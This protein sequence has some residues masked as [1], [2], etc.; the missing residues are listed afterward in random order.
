[1]ATSVFANQSHPVAPYNDSRIDS[2]YEIVCDS[3]IAFS[4]KLKIVDDLGGLSFYS[5]YFHKLFALFNRLLEQGIKV[6]HKNGM[7]FCYNS[8]ADLYF[9][10]W[11]KEETEIYLDS[12]AMCIDKSSNMQYLA[13]YYRMKAQYIQRY[14]PN[15]TPEAVIYYQ[16]SLSYY[17]KSGMKG[18][19]A[20]VVIILR[21]LTI[22]GFQRGD[23]A[24]VCKNILRIAELK[25]Q[26][27]FPMIDFCL[28]EM[29][30]SLYSFYYQNLPEAVYLDSAIYYAKECLAL[31][32]KGVLP[33]YYDHGAID[34]YVA[35]A[36]L[37]NKKEDSEIEPIDSLLSI[38]RMKYD[39][40]DSISL[41]RIYHTKARMFY[42][43]NMIDSAETVAL[44]AQ[45]YLDDGY[46]NRYYSQ[47]KGNI[48]L[49]HDIY[50]DKG[51]FQ[52]V[53]EYNEL[54][55]KK[56]EE[57][58]ANEVKELELQ[59]EFELKESEIERLKS[60]RSYQE[61]RYRMSVLFCF[62]LALTIFFILLL[63]RLKKRDLN[64]QIA[65]INKGK[66]EAKLKLKLKEEY[67]VKMQLERYE[68]LSDFHLKEMELIG[69][70]KDLDQLRQDK[71]L[72]DRQVELY[73][74][75][76]KTCEA[77]ANSKKKDLGFDTQNVVTEDIKRLINKYLKIPVRDVYIRNLERLDKSYIEILRKRSSENLSISYLKY[78][79]CF[80]ISMGIS[81]VAE[82]F[83]I[84]QSSVHMIRYRLKKKFGLGNDDDL[85]LFLQK[86]AFLQT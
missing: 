28:K 83:S 71:E 2:L 37:M 42:N 31:Y 26:Y 16:R 9:G 1:M 19:E 61:H 30:I 77:V 81:D 52:K 59:Y 29:Q 15:R 82:C 86:Y 47:V 36:E 80:A 51:D 60:D 84:E 74:Q 14:F 11:D 21:N 49:L 13:S 50:N 76:L 85:G 65:L 46:G 58:R 43:M 22:D 7:F 10:L 41:A 17:E 69:K 38:A 54:W 70:S 79:I 27:D 48:E 53:I 57:I 24:Y 72:L 34:L 73:C 35:M 20:D 8:I 12:A 25:K 4:R 63:I 68:V 33:D 44:K 67:A 55:M 5:E 64:H 6:N 45:K 3:D 39:V 75:K 23:S 32:E 66:E 56:D 78:C 40:S 62:L 18:K